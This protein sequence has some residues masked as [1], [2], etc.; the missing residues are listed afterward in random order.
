M[1]RHTPFLYILGYSLSIFKTE[2]K[3][4]HVIFVHETP[5]LVERSGIY[6]FYTQRT[7]KADA[8]Y[9]RDRG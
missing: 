6:A 1:I 4:F 5:F 8:A 7:G 3:A 9:G 2:A